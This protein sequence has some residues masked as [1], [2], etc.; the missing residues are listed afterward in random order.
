MD[1]TLFQITYFKYIMSLI[2][3]FKKITFVFLITGALCAESAASSEKDVGSQEWR[4]ILNNVLK[5]RQSAFDKKGV[6]IKLEYQDL[7]APKKEEIETNKMY[8]WWYNKQGCIRQDYSAASDGK[9]VG[10]PIQV[11]L[12]PDMFIRYY[13][14]PAKD[15]AIQADASPLRSSFS[16]KQSALDIVDIR[17]L[18]TT[19]SF[20]RLKD[21]FRDCWLLE[22]STI[23]EKDKGSVS[24]IMY[25]GNLVKK[26]V[27]KLKTG[28][29]F[30]IIVDP[31]KGWSLYLI[32]LTMPNGE[33][34]YT[35][36]SEC[37]KWPGG[38][39][40]PQKVDFTFYQDKKIVTQYRT[41]TLSA[42]FDKQ[43]APKLFTLAGLSI[44][45]G[46]KIND[47]R[48]SGGGLTYWDGQKKVSRG[49][50]M[51]ELSEKPKSTFS[52]M[53][54]FLIGLGALLC[55]FAAVRMALNAK[56]QQ[57]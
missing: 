33:R 55:A 29:Q 39:Y 27:L 32:S 57:E 30:E 21:S 20:F 11:V 36:R 48:K 40:F 1:A 56:K 45:K 23:P 10:L 31:Q 3:L 7:V 22:P 14:T 4:T 17:Y 34:A 47:K 51:Q 18:G 15:S 53:R 52:R 50:V 8:Q 12:C 28:Q 42:D 49:K 25:E 9:S 2:K 16:R 44:P 35:V 38:C 26:I 46:C 24:D 43:I 5:Y 37:K 54:P 41:V 6:E 19:S 13:G